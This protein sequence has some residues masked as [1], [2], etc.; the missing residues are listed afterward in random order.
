[1]EKMGDEKTGRAQ[2]PRKWRRNGGED[3]RNCI[4][5][6]LEIVGEEWKEI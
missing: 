5:R 3:D 2:M 4:K 1:M 6:D